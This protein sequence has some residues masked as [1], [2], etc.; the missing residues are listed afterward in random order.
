MSPPALGR[1]EQDLLDYCRLASHPFDPSRAQ[2]NCIACQY[3]SGLSSMSSECRDSLRCSTSATNCTGGFCLLLSLS[4]SFSHSRSGCSS[5]PFCQLTTSTTTVT[6]TSTSTTSP[7]TSS[8][9]ALVSGSTS[10]LQSQPIVTTDSVA[11]T[12]QVFLSPSSTTASSEEPL[13]GAFL[14]LIIVLSVLC[15]LGIGFFAVRA[16]RQGAIPSTRRRRSRHSQSNSMFISLPRSGFD[17]SVYTNASPREPSSPSTSFRSHRGSKHVLNT[18]RAIVPSG[19]SAHTSGVT[20]NSSQKNW[21]MPDPY[22]ERPS[23]PADFVGTLKFGTVLQPYGFIPSVAPSYGAAYTQG[24][25]SPRG[26]GGRSPR[27][28]RSFGG[29]LCDF[30]TH[31]DAAL[32]FA[33]FFSL[34]SRQRACFSAEPHRHFNR[35]SKLWNVDTRRYL[36][37]ECFTVHSPISTLS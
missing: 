26:A 25:I 9:S 4:R 21:T 32:F 35:A 31:G 30:L 7:T 6:T 28:G 5:Q 34:F 11:S 37:R 14:A 24:S 20:T 8:T 1:G 10:Q 23:A 12:S 27:S 3:T 16:T 17:T 36:M 29:M 18:H 2:T 13:N 19:D 15:C 33:Y 22:G